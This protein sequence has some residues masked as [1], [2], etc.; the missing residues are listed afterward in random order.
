MDYNVVRIAT[1]SHHVQSMSCVKAHTYLYGGIPS[2]FDFTFASS[3]NPN[4][5]GGAL[6]V[7]QPPVAMA[8][9]AR[10]AG[11]VT[12]VEAASMFAAGAVESGTGA[13]GALAADSA[14][15]ALR[16]ASLA[17][18]AASSPTCR[19]YLAFARPDSMKFNTSTSIRCRKVKSRTPDRKWSLYCFHLLPL[20]SSASS[21]GGTTI[22]VSKFSLT[23]L[24]CSILVF[25]SHMVYF[26]LIQRNQN[27]TATL[28][29]SQ[30]SNFVSL[31]CA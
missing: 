8:T 2:S 27:L 28:M 3:M 26:G 4:S 11:G 17:M 19:M 29:C 13:S 12:A 24:F 23:M 15:M 25:G 30:W 10:A 9:A 1:Q 7:G 21:P 14:A 5:M 18:L 6:S 16:S 20:N 31:S 22:K